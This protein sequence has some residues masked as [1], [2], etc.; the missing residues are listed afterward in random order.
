M[1]EKADIKDVDE[2]V[3]VINEA[4]YHAYRN[5]IPLEHFKHPVVTRSQ[6]LRDMKEMI[7]Y[8]YRLENKIVGV[9]ALKPLHEEKVGLIRWVYVHP[10]YQR[11]GIGSALLKYVEEEAHKMKLKRL[12][13]FTHEK[14][15]WAINFY[16]KHG[17]RIIN[18]IQRIAWKDVLMEKTL[19]KAEE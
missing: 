2:I 8:V 18:Y 12:Q 13:L 4:N 9:I 6:I 1:I 7:F 16:K 10:K 5:I 14:A 11:K 15:F 3:L 17:Y 19:N